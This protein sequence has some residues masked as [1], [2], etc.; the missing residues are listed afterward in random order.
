MEEQSGSHPRI[1][2]QD[3]IPLFPL[4]NSSVAECKLLAEEIEQEGP[5]GGF[6][7]VRSVGLK[8]EER[9]QVAVSMN[10]FD[11]KQTPQYRTFELVK[12]E[13]ARYGVPVVGTELV[14]TLPQ[15]AIV[16]SLEYFLRLENFKQ[17]QILD[18]HLIEIDTE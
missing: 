2:A 6:T 15:E 3:T 10:M 14:G 18:N 13:A 16:N 1:G 17:D 7:T 8:F 9:S 5:S 12:L 11:Y 4:K